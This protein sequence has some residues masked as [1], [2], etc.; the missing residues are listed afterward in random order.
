[1][2]GDRPPVEITLQVVGER[3]D[4]LIPLRRIHAQRL[5]GDLF[6][7]ARQLERPDLLAR[8]AD[9]LLHVLAFQ[10]ARPFP[11]QQLVQQYPQRIDVAAGGH[12]AAQDLLRAG[13]IDGPRREARGVAAFAR[14]HDL[15]NPEVQQL[16]RPVGGDENIGGLQVAVHHQVPVRI[17][18]AGADLLQQAD[19]AGRVQVPGELIQALAFH[20]L[21]HQVRKPVIG[22]AGIQQTGDVGVLQA[23]QDLPLALREGRGRA[24]DHLDG[25]LFLEGLVG[26]LAQVHDTHAAAADFAE[27]APGSEAPAGEG[28][29]GP[30]QELA[31]VAETGQ[32]RQD[33]AEHGLVLTG[34]RGSGCVPGGL[35]LL[36]HLGDDLLDL[37]PA[38]GIHGL[39]D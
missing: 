34:A 17:L 27:G 14:R 28:D 13:V 21:D 24:G 4:G 5:A 39:R 33:L 11:G 31:G 36:D 8:C 15:G 29:G 26:P 2:R 12:A 10:P 20:V 19:L 23:S 16:H 30:L 18:H 6:Q 1:M 38:R 35:G 22:G 37:P 3:R 25:H 9:Q 32:Q 7:V